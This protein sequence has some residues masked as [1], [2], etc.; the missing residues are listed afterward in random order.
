MNAITILKRGNTMNWKVLVGIL[1]ILYALSV[2]FFAYRKSPGLIKL[3]KMK[4]GKKMTDNGAILTCYIASGIVFVLGI[5]LFI[6][7]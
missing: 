3:V 2:S 6:L 1:C 7:A 4:L 5:V